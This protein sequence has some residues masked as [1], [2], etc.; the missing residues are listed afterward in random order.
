MV[1]LPPNRIPDPTK[2][3]Q[4]QVPPYVAKFIFKEY[5][6]GPFYLNQ[7]PFRELS[8]AFWFWG[9]AGEIDP[10]K[11]VTTESLVNIDLYLST[12]S[13]I[14]QAEILLNY[15]G[16]KY[17]FFYL[18]FWQAAAHFVDGFQAAGKTRWQAM[19]HF[20]EK[21]DIEEDLYGIESAYRMLAR[22]SKK[23]GSSQSIGLHAA[24]DP[25]QSS[26]N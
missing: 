7:T 11:I 13:Q 26:P 3:L 22:L 16:S 21:Y 12:G 23:K 17:T 20:L 19:A 1:Q 6:R 9:L 24:P 15:K 5:G 10:P 18:E 2:K 25:D 14:Q 4:L 8:T